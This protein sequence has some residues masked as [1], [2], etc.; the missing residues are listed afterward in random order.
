LARTGDPVTEKSPLWGPI[1]LF[2]GF[3]A[4]GAIAE[5][6]R[7]SAI[8]IISKPKFEPAN[9]VECVNKI[10]SAK[11]IKRDLFI[12]ELGDL[13][14]GEVSSLL[15][16][17]RY[18]D[19]RGWGQAAP[20][21]LLIAG[22]DKALRRVVI[23]NSSNYPIDAFICGGLTKVFENNIKLRVD[24]VWP[25]SDCPLKSDIGSQLF[26]GRFF[27]TNHQLTCCSPQEDRRERENNCER[28]NDSLRV[29]V[30]ETTNTPSE[31]AV[32]LGDITINLLVGG[33]VFAY[34]YAILKLF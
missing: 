11:N 5:P 13:L 19:R 14:W 4:L 34:L 8:G 3:V 18:G 7:G 1:W 16:D 12:S 26:F 33:V 2:A 31:D 21:N 24:T 10:H 27:R 25:T 9:I 15:I 6:T 20:V 28:S 17:S 22:Q 23:G 30:N 29:V 32:E